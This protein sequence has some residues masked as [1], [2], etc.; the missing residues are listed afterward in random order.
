[1]KNAFAFEEAVQKGRG[2]VE[3]IIDSVIPDYDP[4][5]PT[6]INGWRNRFAFKK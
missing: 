6:H 3:Y 2:I 5:S 4:V 1:M